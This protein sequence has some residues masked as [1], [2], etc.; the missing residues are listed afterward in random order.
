MLWLRILDVEAALSARKTAHDGE[1]VLRV[2]DPLGF[3][4]GRYRLSSS[5]GTARVSRV[6]ADNPGHDDT[7]QD[8]LVMDIAELSSVYVGGVSPV[9]LAEAGRIRVGA[10]RPDA[11]AEL[12]RMLA[13]ERPAHCLTHF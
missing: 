5:A 11:A 9:T 6:G 8:D 13:V 3:T 4:D 1:L 10:G 2:H 12:A 7:G